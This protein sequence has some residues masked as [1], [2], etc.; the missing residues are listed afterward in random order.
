MS[1]LVYAAIVIVVI[2]GGIF[3]YLVGLDRRVRRLEATGSAAMGG[4]ETGGST[5]V[6]ARTPAEPAETDV[7]P[8]ETEAETTE[9][10]AEA[11]PGER[12]RTTDTP[13]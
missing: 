4:E 7:E 10:E 9:A 12:E 13:D 1:D 5:V 8:A 2:W 6:S 3:F 11:E